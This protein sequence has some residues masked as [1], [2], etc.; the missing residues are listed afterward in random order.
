MLKKA[1]LLG[2]VTARKEFV[3]LNMKCGVAREAE[4]F[5]EMSTM[6]ASA[7]QSHISSMKALNTEEANPVMEM[8]QKT[9]MVDKDKEA[10]MKAIRDKVA[11]QPVASPDAEVSGKHAQSVASPE[12]FLTE[13][14]W[15][16][17]SGPN[18]SVHQ[19]VMRLAARF[20][21]LGLLYPTE[22]A[23]KN[24]VG[25]AVLNQGDAAALMDLV[26]QQIQV[27]RNQT[28][29]MRSQLGKANLPDFN[30]TVA[31]IKENFS[32]W[33]N[34]CYK[35]EHLGCRMSKAGVARP[36]RT[37]MSMPW[38]MQSFQRQMMHQQMQ[39]HQQML[40]HQMMQ[41]MGASHGVDLP[42]FNLLGS[43]AR[44][45]APAPHPALA[46]PQ[47]PQPSAPQ[48]A[49]LPA[50]SP[51]PTRP[52]SGPSP[53]SPQ[54]VSPQQM[55][56]GN[57]SMFA[58]A[59][60]PHVASAASPATAGAASPPSM[61]ANFQNMLH[62]VKEGAEEGEQENDPESAAAGAVQR[63]PAACG[64][65]SLLLASALRPPAA[66]CRLAGEWRRGSARWGRAAA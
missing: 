3:D 40:Q 43:P 10:S 25:I 55:Q 24:I 9:D 28:K 36:A 57:Q 5:R 37:S 23:V 6:T 1:T 29:T 12:V 65:Q 27:Y 51:P 35:D 64:I 7:L 39:Q 19:R 54:Q 2:F 41:N 38:H 18:A 50:Q 30:L 61:V 48:L 49:M 56:A 34:H 15:A 42:G 33:Y 4:A 26:Y 59:M 32:T 53:T 60:A 63:R 45:S 13:S 46:Q 21:N 31:Q 8:L 11:A 16:I 22:H 14:D 47:T 17:M 44:A 20:G 58:L 66:I 62:A 52:A